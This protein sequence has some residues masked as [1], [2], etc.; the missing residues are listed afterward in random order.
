LIQSSVVT[1]RSEVTE[2]TCRNVRRDISD[3]EIR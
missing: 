3:D 1:K 2:P